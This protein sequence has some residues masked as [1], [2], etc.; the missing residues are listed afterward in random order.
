[1]VLN[2]HLYSLHYHNKKKEILNLLFDKFNIQDQSAIIET[3]AYD[4]QKSQ[5][6]ENSFLNLFPENN[7]LIRKLIRCLDKDNLDLEFLS[8]KII[9]VFFEYNEL[10]IK[11]L[12][13]IFNMLIDNIIFIEIVIHIHILLLNLYFFDNKLLSKMFHIDIFNDVN[14]NSKGNIYLMLIEIL[15]NTSHLFQNRYQNSELITDKNIVE[16][17]ENN[18]KNI[19]KILNFNLDSTIEKLFKIFDTG[20]EIDKN[21]K[22]ILKIALSNLFHEFQKNISDFIEIFIGILE[23]KQIFIPKEEKKN[24]FVLITTVFNYNIVKIS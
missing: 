10:S 21:N 18:K 20:G 7:N 3:E 5:I 16:Y 4:Y 14:T 1:M 24:I 6:Y 8:F 15:L 12:P 11:K 19:S 9:S 13:N 23:N 2:N 17:I 22:N